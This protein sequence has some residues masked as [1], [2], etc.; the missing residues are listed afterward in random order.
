[1]HDGAGRGQGKGFVEFDREGLAG[2]TVRPEKGAPHPPA[3]PRVIEGVFGEPRGP[4]AATRDAGRDARL[5]RH[6]VDRDAA[7]LRMADGS[8]ALGIGLRDGFE[9]ID[10]PAQVP[11]VLPADGPFREFF[12]KGRGVEVAKPFVFAFVGA[13]KVVRQGDEASPDEVKRVRAVLALFGPVVP[14]D[15]FSPE[16]RGGVDAEHGRGPAVQSFRDEHV[17]D[18]AF[19]RPHVVGDASLDVVSLARFRDN[20]RLQRT[21]LRRASTQGLAEYQ[22]QRIRFCF[23]RFHRVDCCDMRRPSAHG[24][25]VSAASDF[26]QIVERD[27]GHMRPPINQDYQDEQD[28]QDKAE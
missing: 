17:R 25:A 18:N 11:Q 27:V 5:E 2:L 24:E 16:R 3:C 12:I 15:L 4:V 7:P 6:R 26:Q 19:I 9:Q 23:P 13:Q 14:D 1:M 20:L 28:G 22:P 10:R 8:D 21:D